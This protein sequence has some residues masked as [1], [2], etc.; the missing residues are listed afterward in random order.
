MLSWVK[1]LNKINFGSG[2]FSES[3]QDKLL[4]YIF[5][6]IKTTNTPPLCIEFGYSSNS[7][8]KKSFANTSKLI[9]EKG[10]NSLLLD[11]NNENPE[12]NLQKHLL[13]SENICKI[14]RKYNVPKEPE[15]ISIDIDSIDL[16][17][18]ES[19]IK[20]Y[21][22]KL[23]SVE[24]NCNFPINRSIT[25]KN[26]PS[27]PINTDRA[28]GA[29]LKALNQVA[30]NNGYVLLWV[31]EELDA[32]FIRRDLINDKSS[33]ISYPLT[34][35]EYATNIPAMEPIKNKDIINYF[36]DY[37]IF[38]NTSGDVNQS[39]KAAKEICMKV[40]RFNLL[41]EIKWI[42]RIPEK[43]RRNKKRLFSFLG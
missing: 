40:L 24:Y 30:E 17:I 6:N 21:K 33:L 42:K 36:L 15:Y 9:I 5:S 1:N 31:V 3:Y 25:I 34:K 39:T 11:K 12:I 22:A 32:F 26:D 14:F 41:R 20:K 2:K 27:I 13:T 8:T 28:F 23:F 38:L 43:W 35:W 18:F 7:L 10:W 19:L 16:W 4:D 37:E 29:S